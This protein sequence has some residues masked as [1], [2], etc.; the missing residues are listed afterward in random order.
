MGILPPPTWVKIFWQTAGSVDFSYIFGLQRETFIKRR[1]PFTLK[2]SIA[3][4]TLI[5]LLICIIGAAAYRRVPKD[6][7]LLAPLLI[8]LIAA[9]VSAV[10]KGIKAYQQRKAANRLKESKFMPAELTMN[11]D[12]AQMQ[13]FSR[14]APGSAKA[15]EN[16]RRGQAN[17]ISAVQRV[18][19][20]NVNKVAAAA[21]AAQGQANDAF[22]QI[23]TRGQQFSENAFSRLGQANSQ[24]AGQKRQNRMEFNQAKS[25]L[26]AASDQ[27]Y[28]SAFND[29]LNGGMA[30]GAIAGGNAGSVF[31]TIGGR[32]RQSSSDSFRTGDYNGEISNNGYGVLG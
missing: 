26:L 25:Q 18:A 14:R 13:A 22:D 24:I 32:R 9:G 27:N 11:R 15:E 2:F 3:M 19:G 31:P 29:I 10:G 30:A 28:F 7:L 12:L 8:P 5:I 17:A 16:V 20:G 21:V 1:F 6:S 4:A 23:Q